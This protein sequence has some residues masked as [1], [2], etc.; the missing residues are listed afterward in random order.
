M[1]PVFDQQLTFQFSMLASDFFSDTIDVIMWDQNR[2]FKNTLIGSYQF[3]IKTTYEQ[4]GHEFFR[5]WVPLSNLSDRSRQL[6]MQ[7]AIEKQAKEKKKKPV[8]GEDGIEMEDEAA[9]LKPNARQASQ[10]DVNGF[11]L[12]SVGVLGPGDK[13]KPHDDDEPA[14][15]GDDEL[16][17][18]SSLDLK[19]SPPPPRP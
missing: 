3:D 7:A 15:D 1:N 6:A 19:V 2:F 17:V 10:S 11:L 4:D 16:E 12:L 14:E 18:M 8:E 13:F 9:P 5:K